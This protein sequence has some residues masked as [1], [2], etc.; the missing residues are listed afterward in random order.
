[1]LNLTG[2]SNTDL[3]L[4]YGTANLALLSEYDTNFSDMVALLP[5]YV[6]ELLDAGQ[7]DDAKALLEFAVACNADSKRIWLLLADMY[8]EEGNRAKL[9]WLC[10]A[11]EGL[12]NLTRLAVQKEL[13]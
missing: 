7:Q 11:S 12:P 2:I 13:A 1:M 10:E 3:K 4:S 5:D 6:A 9:E 8:R